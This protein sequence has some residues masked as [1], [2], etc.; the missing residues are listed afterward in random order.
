MDG[1]LETRYTICINKQAKTITIAVSTTGFVILHPL[2][3]KKAFLM[4]LDL[5][6]EELEGSIIGT[7]GDM[8]S[9]MS[10]DTKG[11]TSLR[12]YIMGNT[13]EARQRFRDQVS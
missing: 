13:D 7:I 12:R 10:P 4:G 11:W 9:P 6:R 5:P 8:D 1:L 2:I 3:H